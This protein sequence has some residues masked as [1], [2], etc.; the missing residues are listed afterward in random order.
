MDSKR[1]NYHPARARLR[2]PRTPP[3]QAAGL[4]TNL[5]GATLGLHSTSQ[6]ECLAT[7]VLPGQL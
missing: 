1:P 2:P 7:H 4:R 6:C 3:Q 5:L